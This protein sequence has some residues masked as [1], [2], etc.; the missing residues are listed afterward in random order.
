MYKCT[1]I[2]TRE[3]KTHFYMGLIRL[4]WNIDGFFENEN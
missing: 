1:D 4:F 3:Y 2:Q